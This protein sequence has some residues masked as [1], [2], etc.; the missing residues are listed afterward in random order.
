[1][2]HVGAVRALAADDLYVYSGG[3]DGVVVVRD[4][5]SLDRRWSLRGHDRPVIKVL[6]A[7]ERFL[8]LDNATAVLWRRPRVSVASPPAAGA[9]PLAN[10]TATTNAS[11]SPTA[12]PAPRL[13]EP[14]CGDGACAQGEGYST[15]CRDCGCPGGLVCVDNACATEEQ[16]AVITP[17]PA[18]DVI[19]LDAGPSEEPSAAPVPPSLPPSSVVAGVLV[20]LAGGAAIAASRKR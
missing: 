9:E 20:V 7:G 11:A 6:P 17:G 8:S 12:E 3:D 1:V 13:V 15:C 4:L 10:G 16:A 14:R 19:V 5:G 2:D 18:E